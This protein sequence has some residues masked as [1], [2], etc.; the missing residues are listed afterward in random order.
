[1]NARYRETSVC[2]PGRCLE[3]EAVGVVGYGCARGCL[4]E[5]SLAGRFVEDVPAPELFGEGVASTPD[6]ADDI[7]P[8]PESW[9]QLACPDWTP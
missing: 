9:A 3:A 2:P 1:M 6:G 4:V 5:H 8:A 7:E